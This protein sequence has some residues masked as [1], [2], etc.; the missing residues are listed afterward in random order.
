[1]PKTIHRDEYEVLL[2]LLRQMRL[3]AGL[4]QVDLSKALGR[5]QSLISKIEQGV[6]RLDVMQLKDI[7]DVC[8]RSLASFC[9]EYEKKLA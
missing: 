7:C 2:V 9:R 4:T 1:M 5:P 8:G 3:K 6:I